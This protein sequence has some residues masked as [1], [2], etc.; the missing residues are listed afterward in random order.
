MSQVEF[1]L[2]QME[3][4]LEDACT[5]ID[6][7]IKCKNEDKGLSDL[8]A[9]LSEQELEHY[10]MLKS[11][12]AKMID[13]MKMEQPDK[14]HKVTIIYEWEYQKYLEKE[15]KIKMKHASLMAR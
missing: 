13:K 10:S 14:A 2:E 5:Y 3:E 7:A 6:W 1:M 9:K 15:H 11:Y 4:E 8:L 12:F